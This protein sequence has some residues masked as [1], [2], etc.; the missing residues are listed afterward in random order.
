M[1][2]GLLQ[3]AAVSLE[4]GRGRVRAHG[5]QSQEYIRQEI[6]SSVARTASICGSDGPSYLG[7]DIESRAGPVGGEQD[8]EVCDK[9][10][11]VDGHG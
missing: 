1:R 7:R 9:R 5:E 6:V 8:G 3:R 10:A 11:F 2:V 4:G